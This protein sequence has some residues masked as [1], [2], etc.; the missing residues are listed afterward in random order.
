M[1]YIKAKTKQI[2]NILF[3]VLWTKL[4][5]IPNLYVETLIPN[6]MVYG[7][8]FFGRQLG[9]SEVVRVGREY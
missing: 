8:E 5:L 9:L 3:Q 2:R 6:V 7:D 1:G 4:C